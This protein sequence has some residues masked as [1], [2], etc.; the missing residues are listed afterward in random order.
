MFPVTFFIIFLVNS[1]LA[2]ENCYEMSMCIYQVGYFIVIVG[3]TINSF[4]MK[5]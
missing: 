5:L 3:L 1:L 2:N 4:D